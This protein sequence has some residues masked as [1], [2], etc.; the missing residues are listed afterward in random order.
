MV[1]CFDNNPLI[2]INPQAL[3]EVRQ[4]TRFLD[5]HHKEPIL[6]SISPSSR[7]G[8]TLMIPIYLNHSYSVSGITVISDNNINRYEFKRRSTS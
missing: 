6:H 5:R 3:G 2:Q 7:K 8:Q 1:L 4:R